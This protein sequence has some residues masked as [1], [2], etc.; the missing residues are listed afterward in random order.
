MAAIIGTHQ[1]HGP[2]V[3]LNGEL[4]PATPALRDGGAVSIR[5]GVVQK[6]NAAGDAWEAVA[7]G[8]KTFLALT[9]T[10]AALVQNHLIKVNDAGDALELGRSPEL[11]DGIKNYTK[12]PVVDE[13][14]VINLLYDDYLT[15]GGSADVNLTP[16]VILT[17]RFYG[18]SDGTLKPAAG[19]LN[20][21]VARSGM[22][23]LGSETG[24][25]SGSNSVTGWTPTQI[26]SLSEQ[27]LRSLQK[28]WVKGY[29]FNVQNVRYYGGWVADLRGPR[30][31]S[32]GAAVTF[33]TNIPVAY[34]RG[35]HSH[36]R[37][38][39][40]QHMAGLYWWEGT[41]YVPLSPSVMDVTASGHPIID[42]HNRDQLFT[43]H[44][45][46]RLWIPH[47][48]PKANRPATATS[49]LWVNARFKGSGAEEPSAAATVNGD[50]FYSVSHSIWER[51]VSAS[52][53]AVVWEQGG[54]IGLTSNK[55]HFPNFFIF[56]GEQANANAAAN[57]IITNS[58]V[59]N[60]TYLYYNT[61]TSQIENILTFV[62]AGSPGY[63]YATE[64]VQLERRVEN[65][66]KTSWGN[67]PIPPEKALNT[68]TVVIKT[69]KTIGIR[70]P[71]VEN[72][73]I[74]PNY[75]G[76][77]LIELTGGEVRLDG[78]TASS[79][80]IFLRRAV[81][82]TPAAVDIQSVAYYR[83]A[84]AAVQLRLPVALAAIDDLALAVATT[85]FLQVTVVGASTSGAKMGGSANSSMVFKVTEIG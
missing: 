71:F 17:P 67:A 73:T 32:N 21:H 60:H 72:L 1:I 62:A 77:M 66:A 11:F 42:A 85:Y 44:D 15:S 30:A 53:S 3:D 47:W 8:G 46:P 84:G 56:L 81:A 23:W 10:P 2:I 9:D 26:G 27:W 5:G 28:V 25:I 39:V 82:G 48:I 22:A 4:I 75:T 33:N 36:Q 29:S 79:V 74:T 50:I 51:R 35:R 18:Y 78:A 34:G 31:L 13:G 38:N 20:T 83:D 55:T 65:W 63:N 58:V 19:S 12:L 37:T 68:K 49:A 64:P 76:K 43:D 80:T 52:G 70:Q 69:E 24:A 57:R 40:L 14:A 6:V 54:L 45:A 61:T 41:Y 7:S 59:A 16:G